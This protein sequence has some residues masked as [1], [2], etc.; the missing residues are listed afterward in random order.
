MFSPLFV[1]SFPTSSLLTPSRY[2]LEHGLKADGRIDEERIEEIG[3]GGS[4][5]TFFTETGN[6]KY[7]PRSVFVDLDPSVRIS[8]RGYWN[9]PGVIKLMDY[10]PLMR[11]VPATSVSSS[12]LNSWLAER[13]MPPTTVRQ[14]SYPKILRQG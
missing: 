1:P 12:T 3:D 2:L 6:G 8:S 7:V 11:S 10:S 13:R 14:R 4:R 5:E 9:K